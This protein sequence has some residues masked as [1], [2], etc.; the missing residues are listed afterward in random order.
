[1][2]EQEQGAGLVRELE[3]GLVREQELAGL[4]REQEQVAG[5][6]QRGGNIDMWGQR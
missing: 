5:L 1:M 4:V 2:R 6:A 3:V